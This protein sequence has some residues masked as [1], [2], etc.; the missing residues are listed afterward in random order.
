M[1]PATNVL[2]KL[3]AHP[4]LRY[5]T[6]DGVVTFTRLAS[7]LKRDILQ[8]QPISESNPSLVPAILPQPI[9]SFLGASLGL[10]TRISAPTANLFEGH[11]SQ[12]KSI[13]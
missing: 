1:L 6:L 5:L 3:K 4:V 7:H 8:P 9:I 13:T 12:S 10:S 11:S 2:E